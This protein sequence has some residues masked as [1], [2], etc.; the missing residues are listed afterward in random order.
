MACLDR[1][2][3]MSGCVAAVDYNEPWRQWIHRFKHQNQPEWA[4]VFARI[5]VSRSE[6]RS[7]LARASIWMP[8]PMAPKALGERGYNP[9]WELT[10]HL[11][12]LWVREVDPPGPTV[13]PHWLLKTTDTPA[14]HTLTRSERMV[15]LRHAFTLEPLAIHAI[16]GQTVALID[17][18]MTTGATLEAAAKALQRTGAGEVVGVVLARTPARPIGES[19]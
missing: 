6:V 19:P 7:M 9:A 14:Q 15:N 11:H 18:V 2:G 4:K 8:I 13:N 1:A 16:R 5:L 17:D 12:R 10:R 3:P